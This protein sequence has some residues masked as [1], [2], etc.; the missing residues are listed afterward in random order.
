M[1]SKI[2]NNGKGKIRMNIT[3]TQKNM[4]SIVFVI[5]I[6]IL[7]FDCGYTSL[8]EEL[9]Q[10]V[11]PKAIIKDDV[12][13]VSGVAKSRLKRTNISFLVMNPG[14]SINEL[15]LLSAKTDV[16]ICEQI[17]AGIGG[18]YE[19]KF[20]ADGG[21]GE[22]KIYINEESPNGQI[23]DGLTVLTVYRR[24]TAEFVSDKTGNIYFNGD[25]TE[26]ELNI[27]TTPNVISQLEIHIKTVR[28]DMNA[29]GENVDGS[30][31]ISKTETLYTDSDGRANLHID[32]SDDF[33]D[34]FGV[35][36][37]TAE[38]ADESSN[39]ST[40][41]STRFSRVNASRGVQNMNHKMGVA[42]HLQNGWD[43]NGFYGAGQPITPNVPGGADSDKFYDL[44]SDAGY[45]MQ[46]EELHWRIFDKGKVIKNQD[47]EWE[48]QYKG[49][50]FRSDQKQ[51]LD[52]MKERGLIPLIIL[53][54]E[55]KNYYTKA[56]DGSYIR[57]YENPLYIEAYERYCYEAVK[58]TLE[59]TDRYEIMNEYNIGFNRFLKKDASGNWV[60]TDVD[61]KEYVM[62]MKAAYE[63]AHRAAA[64]VGKTITVYGIASAQ[65]KNWNDNR[66]YYTFE[67]G[68]KS[69]FPGNKT[70]EWINGILKNGGGRYMD[71]LSFHVYTNTYKPEQTSGDKA[72]LVDDI[73]RL[74][75]QNNCERI[76]LFMSET[77]YSTNLNADGTF[78]NTEVQQAKYE[79]RDWARL[80]NKVSGVTW[81]NAIE[82][83]QS[84]GYEH[85]LGHIK[86]HTS[87]KFTTGTGEEKE[88]VSDI[89]YEAKRVY[90]AIANWNTLLAN[91]ELIQENI[92]GSI[93]DY[94]FKTP[95]D[96]T[97]HML[98]NS[99]D[100]TV[101]VD[102]TANSS[103]AVLYDMYGNA[104][105]I[106]PN[107]GGYNLTI[108]GEPIYLEESKAKVV[109]TDESDKKIEKLNDNIC[110]VK[111][112]VSID[113]LQTKTDSAFVIE[114][115]YDE[116]GNITDIKTESANPNAVVSVSADLT[117]KVRVYI[118]KDAYTMW[119][120]IQ[121]QQ[122]ER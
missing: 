93:Y 43:N 78:V 14:K 1:R 117:Q 63:G 54:L 96:R 55:N 45:Y 31:I 13:T 19:F 47:G 66:G 68:S 107:N 60:Y 50:K 58:A 109:F 89:P 24:P 72:A 104:T 86:M 67:D 99:D 91:S 64:E 44:F 85:S 82:K 90:L 87:Y 122:I 118:W 103:S 21:Y 59:Y 79:L 77:G 32:L 83:P 62:L 18:R 121:Y 27:S 30:E 2:N 15:T 56:D 70:Y 26:F 108:S 61:Y 11:S 9:N 75:N 101:N 25:N 74:L 119:P 71:E 4:A 81:Y 8:A 42:Q 65:I 116:K 38:V 17:Q 23:V 94:V 34:K 35:F 39:K 84:N 48:N 80:Y 7:V 3:K 41:A 100:V 53:G 98:W 105:D 113:T 12:V 33:V 52:Q 36:K 22:Y 5:Y 114:A 57:P 20:C 73:K 88:W 97:V 76:P 69:K 16:C 46:R 115:A 110:R 106:T 10:N 37:I 120:I 28:L 29:S 111:A 92:N 49:Y 102:V 51:Y 95:D 40:S 112:N 6:I